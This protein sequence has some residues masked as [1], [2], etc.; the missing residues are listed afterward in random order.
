MKN[1]D[2]ITCLNRCEHL[3]DLDSLNRLLDEKF[4]MGTI[5][6]AEL[7]VLIELSQSFICTK[8]SL[9]YEGRLGAHYKQKMNVMQILINSLVEKLNTGSENLTVYLAIG[10][11]KS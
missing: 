10:D 9:G 8:E 6:Y 3:S 7:D 4:E 11:T 2:F 5:D 1:D